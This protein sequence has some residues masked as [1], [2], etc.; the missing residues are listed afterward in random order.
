MLLLPL[1]QHP[2]VKLNQP[3]PFIPLALLLLAALLGRLRA[4]V[5]LLLAAVRVRD[6]L[7]L[8]GELVALGRALALQPPLLGDLPVAR[9]SRPR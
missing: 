7:L 3:A 8:V 9:A 2:L 6:E 4:L 1:L 5:L